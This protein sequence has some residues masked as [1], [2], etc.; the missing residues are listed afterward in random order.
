MQIYHRLLPDNPVAV[1]HLHLRL[2]T[3]NQ[4]RQRVGLLLPL[5]EIEEEQLLLKWRH[6]H[7]L[8]LVEADLIS[9]L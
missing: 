8:L 7:H 1:H 3:F 9:Q 4:Y 2:V 6:P 5:T